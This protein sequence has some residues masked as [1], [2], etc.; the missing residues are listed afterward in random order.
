MNAYYLLVWME[1][2]GCWWTAD[3]CEGRSRRGAVAMLPCRN[4]RQCRPG[5]PWAIVGLDELGEALNRKPVVEAY[6]VLETLATA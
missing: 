3:E 6:G 1:D 5:R 4:P 2:S